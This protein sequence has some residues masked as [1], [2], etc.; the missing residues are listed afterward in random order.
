LQTDADVLNGSGDDAVGD[1]GEGAC[2][3]VLAV[4]EVADAG[5]EGRVPGG[6]AL[7]EVPSG[8]MEGAKLDGYAGTDAEEGC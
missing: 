8:G 6:V 5:D 4:A 3:V 7:L 2:G 1:A